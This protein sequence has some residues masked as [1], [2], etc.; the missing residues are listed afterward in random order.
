MEKVIPFSDSS[1]F[2]D[3]VRSRKRIVFTNGVF[4][5]LHKGHLTYLTQA[6]DLGDFLWIGVNSDSS[7]KRLKGPSRPM[8]SEEDRALLLSCLQFVD[9][10]TVFGEDTP[11]ELIR[12][13]RPHVHVKGGDYDVEALPETPLVR[14]L[15]G[16]VKIL[17]FVPGFSSTKLIQKIRSHSET[18]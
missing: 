12:R 17:P 7:V 4:D 2:S 16:E 18:K 5:L 11:L 13:I 1:A 8:N 3:S 14:E 9:A 6:R 15:G 10:V